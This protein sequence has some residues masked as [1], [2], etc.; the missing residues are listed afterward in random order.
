MKS[1][2]INYYAK[3]C[4]LWMAMLLNVTNFSHRNKIYFFNLSKL[5]F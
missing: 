4:G 5:V 1:A 3:L 2:R